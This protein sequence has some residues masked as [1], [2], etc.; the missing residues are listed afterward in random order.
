MSF[1]AASRMSIV[2]WLDKRQPSESLVL[3]AV[4]LLV[5]LLTGVGIWLFEQ[6]IELAQFISFEVIGESLADFG[7]WTIGLLPVLGGLI[8]GLLV[9]YFVGP[10]RHHGV[11]GIMEA[12][13]L[14]GGR[15]RYKRVPI[16]AVASALSIGSGASVGPED[17]SVQIGANLGSMFGQW[18]H[19]S[20]ERVKSLVAAG[21]AGGIA[22]AF[23]APIAGVFFAIEI[24]LGEISARVFG[25]VL[26]SAV[27]SAVFSQAVSGPQPAFAVPPYTFN[28]FGELPLYVGLGVLAGPLAALYVR[29]LYLAHDFFHHLKTPSWLKP[30]LAGVLVGGVGVFMPQIFGVGYEVVEA[31]LNGANY[32]VGLLAALVLAKLV[33]TAVSI[34]GGFQGGVFAPSLFLGAMLGGAYGMIMANLFPS[35]HIIPATFAMVG[36]A[37]VLVGAVHAPLTA[38][39]L[40]FEMTNDYRIILPLMLSVAVSFLLAQWLQR[41]SVYTLSLAR[42]G[43]RIEHGHDVDV[44]EAITVGE[45]MATDVATLSESDT[46]AAASEK[47]MRLRHHGLPVLD[48]NGKLVGILTVQDIE[49]AQANNRHVSLDKLT[50]GETCTR[51]LLVAYPDES[52]GVALRRMGVRDIGRLPVVSRDDSQQLLGVLRRVDVVRAYDAARTRRAAL[53]HRA[54]Q[55]RLGLYSDLDVEEVLVEPGS[56][57]DGRSVQAIPWPHD[58]VVASVRRGQEMLLPHGDTILKAGDALVIVYE[59]GAIDMVRELCRQPEETAVSSDT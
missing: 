15:L 30:A 2:R 21:A 44:L 10:E 7:P 38:I 54:Q 53:R 27:V 34:G 26:L 29:A 17:P 51:S 4:A 39:I 16:K 55:V 41:D 35:M 6:L 28:S 13:A 25:A 5:G 45:V 31:V 3:S 56:V 48:Q 40:L 50:V 14:A 59:N 57:C 11:A 32:T 20:D 36:M 46:L 37:A 1:W 49:R 22:A 24:V 23:N 47:L 18:L 43:L 12:V 58:C 42:K 8:V 9:H 19:L 52:L 33:L